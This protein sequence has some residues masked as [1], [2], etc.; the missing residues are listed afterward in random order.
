MLAA[1]IV[2]SALALCVIGA[3]AIYALPTRRER[4]AAAALAGLLADH[5]DHEDERQPNESCRE[6]VARLAVQ[7]ADAVL[8]RLDETTEKAP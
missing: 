8:K 7:H 3:L 1:A 2:L 5:L 6:A 4:M